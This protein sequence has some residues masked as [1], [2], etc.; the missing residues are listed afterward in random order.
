MKNNEIWRVKISIA[1][2]VLHT[3]SH[4][5]TVTVTLRLNNVP[6]WARCE[7]AMHYSLY[8]TVHDTG[9]CHRQCT[10]Y[11]FRSRGRT[12]DGARSESSLI[13]ASINSPPSGINLFPSRFAV[14]EEIAAPFW[15]NSWRHDAADIGFFDLPVERRIGR[16]RHPV[17]FVD[18]GI[19][20]PTVPPSPAPDPP[21]GRESPLKIRPPASPSRINII[22]NNT[23]IERKNY[24]TYILLRFKSSWYACNKRQLNEQM[25]F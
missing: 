19:P 5:L 25:C 24:L 1:G 12:R 2:A 10:R 15:P 13:H 23:L 4:G 3:Q 22:D 11:R 18:R 6:H 21:F 14:R 7:T 9:D 20:R 16:G 8:L 17:H